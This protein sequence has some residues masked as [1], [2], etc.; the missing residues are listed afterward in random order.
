MWITQ[1]GCWKIPKTFSFCYGNCINARPSERP[2]NLGSRFVICRH[3]LK[4]VQ[5]LFP[6][7]KTDSPLNPTNVSMSPTRGRLEHLP[8]GGAPSFSLLGFPKVSELRAGLTSQVVNVGFRRRALEFS[9]KLLLKE[10]KT[11]APL[12]QNEWKYFTSCF[13]KLIQRVPS[14]CDLECWFF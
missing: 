4:K 8:H 10:R 6:Y 14:R 5:D 13:H 11:I 12:D 1:W 3:T 2:G 9:R 7:S